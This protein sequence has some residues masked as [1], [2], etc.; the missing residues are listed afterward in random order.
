MNLKIRQ[1]VEERRIAAS[2][3]K[4]QPTRRGMEAVQT[5]KFSRIPEEG[6]GA[7]KK[8]VPEKEKRDERAAR[9]RF[10]ISSRRKASQIPGAKRFI[11]AGCYRL[12]F[13]PNP[14]LQGR[15]SL[16]S[17]CPKKLVGVVGLTSR[18]AM[19]RASRPLNETGQKSRGGL[20]R[21]LDKGTN[22]VI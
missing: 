11:W 19:L 21:S 13:G 4:P 3:L 22:L 6:S 8:Y 15:A 9:P 14:D 10:R 1:L 18:L 16:W 7:W 17:H 20:D 2:P 12:R 5:K